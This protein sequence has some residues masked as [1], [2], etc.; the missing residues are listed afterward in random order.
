M[1]LRIQG[2]ITFEGGQIDISSADVYIRLQ[3]VSRVDAA[4]VTI[5][6]QRVESLP[7][8]TN[9]SNTIPFELI[10]DIKNNRGSLIIAAHVD[11]SKDRKISVGDYITMQSYSI[12]IGSPCTY[13][14]VKVRRVNR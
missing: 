12:L 8:G 13:Y 2:D 9:T 14:S 10:A 6:E 1:T 11:L 5:A 7:Q 4:S 3:D